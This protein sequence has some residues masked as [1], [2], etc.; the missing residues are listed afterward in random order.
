MK[1]SA[2]LV[3]WSLLFFAAAC[4]L[5]AQAQKK[6]DSQESCRKFVQTLYDWYGAKAVHAHAGRSSDSALKY[7][8]SAFSSEL[9]RSLTEDSNAQKKADEI[10][11]LDFDPF[12]GGQDTCE[13]YSLKKVT[14]TGSKC[15]VEVFGS[16][17]EKQAKADVVPE[18]ELTGGRWLFVNFSYPNLG[19]HTD[20]LS[21]LKQLRNDRLA[22]KAK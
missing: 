16:S 22:G 4:P 10:V 9:T 3:F 11:G 12:L 15:Q 6:A 14:I 17:C 7:K 1:T 21:T 18:L 13:P 20:L 19:E 5:L 8:R 2:I